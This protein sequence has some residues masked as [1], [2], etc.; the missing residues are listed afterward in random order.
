MDRTLILVKPDGFQRQLVG[1]VISRWER[2]GW[3]LVGLKAL[4][5]PKAIAEQHYAEHAG[6][7]HCALALPLERHFNLSFNLL[8]TCLL[9]SLLLL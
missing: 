6:K 5:T 2:K 7:F 9:S 3:K 4:A 8:R 1:E